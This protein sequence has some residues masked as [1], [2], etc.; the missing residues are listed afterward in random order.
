MICLYSVYLK[1]EKELYQGLY[2]AEFN[3]Y[4]VIFESHFIYI[5]IKSNKKITL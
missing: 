2:I 1:T 4:F 5:L 3:W